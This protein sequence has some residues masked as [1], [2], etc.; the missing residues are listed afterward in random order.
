MSRIIRWLKA[1]WSW[2]G[3][4][5][6]QVTIAFGVIAAFYVLFEYRS[7]ATDTEIK[8][9]LDLQTRYGQKELLDARY[10]LESYWLSS[11]SADDLAKAA[12]PT[13]NEKITQVV[14][15]QKLDGN[16]FLLAD[17][18]NQ[19][20]VCVKERICDRKTA[21]AAFKRDIVG[22]RNTYFDLFKTWEARWGENLGEVP[23]KIL[24]E[25][26]HET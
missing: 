20:A 1:F 23:Y 2:L 11:K 26:C 7:N 9:T 16:V 6:D 22:L 14:L 25:T 18:Y 17:F 19:V 12:G 24:S 5:H 10:K 21:C 4:S 15:D 3:T 13:K 8:R